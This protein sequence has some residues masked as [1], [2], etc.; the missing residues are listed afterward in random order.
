M[1]YEF[2]SKM[3]YTPPSKDK[4][5]EIALN[6]SKHAD[7][8]AHRWFKEAVEKLEKDLLKSENNLCN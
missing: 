7:Q 3:F 2:F 6:I 4:W 8:I 5:S 1:Q